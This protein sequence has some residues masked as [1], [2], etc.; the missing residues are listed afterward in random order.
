[1]LRHFTTLVAAAA[2]EDTDT[3]PMRTVLELMNTLRTDTRDDA[4]PVDLHLAD[5]P[6]GGQSPYWLR[7]QQL[8]CRLRTWCLWRP[9]EIRKLAFESSWILKSL[10]S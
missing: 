2:T 3:I 8:R 4:L 10:M 1:M 5:S 7:H 6:Y 9:C